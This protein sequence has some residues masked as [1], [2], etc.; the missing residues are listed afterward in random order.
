[1]FFSPAVNVFF[2]EVQVIIS[3][4]QKRAEFSC[5]NKRVDGKLGRSIILAILFHG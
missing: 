5:T 4:K 1:M 3:E 2:S